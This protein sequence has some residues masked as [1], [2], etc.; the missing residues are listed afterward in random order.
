MMLQTGY[1]IICSVVNLV[2]HGMVEV[3]KGDN[4]NEVPTIH[5]V[6]LIILQL[7]SGPILFGDH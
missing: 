6:V 4:D 1:C 5:H 7:R 2:T 3:D